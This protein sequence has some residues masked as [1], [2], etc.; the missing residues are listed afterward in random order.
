M[1]SHSRSRRTF[2]GSGGNEGFDL[3]RRVD[4][5][6][7]PARQGAIRASNNAVARTPA[8]FECNGN[9]ESHYWGVPAAPTDHGTTP[10]VPSQYLGTT[11]IPAA[12]AAAA[13]T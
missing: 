7:L 4:T 3:N 1:G 8:P 9:S 2:F 10:L 11:L 6:S 5:E 13:A 12:S